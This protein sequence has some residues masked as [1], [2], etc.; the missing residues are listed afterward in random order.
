MPGLAITLD[1]SLLISEAD[2]C[3]PCGGSGSSAPC[4]YPLALNAT[5]LLGI[6]SALGTEIGQK[7]TY[8]NSPS[9]YVSLAMPADLNAYVI[10]IKVGANSAPVDVRLTHATGGATVYPSQYLLLMQV[11]SDEAVTEIE[12]QGTANISWLA[13]GVQS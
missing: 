5:G 11:A 13:V 12:I 9:A 4:E 10:C 3:S 7:Q 6:A 2:S 1:G 8:V